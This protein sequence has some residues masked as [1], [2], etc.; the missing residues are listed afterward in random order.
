MTI[1]QADRS[2]GPEERIKRSPL[3]DPWVRGAEVGQMELRTSGERTGQ[4]HQ[5]FAIQCCVRQLVTLRHPIL[6][7]SR[8]WSERPDMLSVEE[9]FEA[10]TAPWDQS[11]LPKISRVR[12]G[13]D[14]EEQTVR[15]AVGNMARQFSDARHEVQRLC[16]PVLQADP[17]RSTW[18]ELVKAGLQPM[19]AAFLKLWSGPCEHVVLDSDMLAW[20]SMM[21]EV[22]GRNPD[23]N[24]RQPP[25]KTPTNIAEYRELE[26]R[27]RRQQRVYLPWATAQEAD[28]IIRSEIPQ[29]KQE[30]CHVAA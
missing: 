10:I 27:A 29:Q 4:E 6:F 26:W 13:D 28:A 16:R 1:R 21:P 12:K 8:I 7:W 15:R 14:P 20:H 2:L 18:D 9:W 19:W 30:R 24:S 11:V 22:I 5:Q 3:K 23:F 17:P 25:N